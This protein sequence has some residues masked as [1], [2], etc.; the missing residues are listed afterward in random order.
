[1]YS[2]RLIPYLETLDWAKANMGVMD[3]H[4]GLFCRKVKDCEKK[5]LKI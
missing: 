2:G 1:M 3:E 4:S 5:F